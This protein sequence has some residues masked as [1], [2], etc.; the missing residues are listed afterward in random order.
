MNRLGVIAGG[1]PLP[2]M[3]AEHCQAAGREVFV[4][5]V[6]GAALPD[7]GRFPHA[8]VELGRIGA[9]LR[10]L[11]QQDCREIVFIGPVRR[12]S[13]RHLKLDLAGWC[14]LPRYLLA[15]KGGDDR[16]LRTL[17]A[18][19][20]DKG[21]RVRGAHEFLVELC[22]PPG[23]LGAIQP[24]P[25]DLADIRLG[26]QAARRHG[27]RDKGQAVVIRAGEVLE[28]EAEDGTDAMLRRCV[29]QRNPVHQPGRAGVLVKALKPGQETRIDLPTLGVTS[30]RLAA[31]AGLAGIAFEAGATLL[32]EAPAMVREAD[33]LG[34]FLTG[35]P[36]TGQE[37]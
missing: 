34:L 10:A 4:A 11:R 32:V 13:I 23:V 24:R 17:I 37:A 30:I 20:E 12:P 31:E 19:F 29:A 22:V 8:W 2:G 7:I 26:M 1:G 14:F 5:G 6:K 33:A 35:L 28:R 21:I 15:A 3:L 36:G 27:A 18:W 25:E 9:L 16:L